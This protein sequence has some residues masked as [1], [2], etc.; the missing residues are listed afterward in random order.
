MSADKLDT[1]IA[2]LYKELLYAEKRLAFFREQYAKYVV[3][4]P[5]LATTIAVEMSNAELDVQRLNQSIQN[6]TDLQRRL[7]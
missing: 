3:R 7:S 6:S 2:D 4:T 1:I 5:D